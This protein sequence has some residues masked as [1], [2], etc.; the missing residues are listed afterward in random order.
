M[1]QR[2]GPLGGMSSGTNRVPQNSGVTG[3]RVQV[4]EGVR[5]GESYDSRMWSYRHREWRGESREN[6]RKSRAT[7]PPPQE[8]RS[9]TD[10]RNRGGAVRCD[11]FKGQG[12]TEEQFMIKGGVASANNSLQA[13]SSGR[14]TENGIQLGDEPTS[15]RSAAQNYRKFRKL[16]CVYMILDAYTPCGADK[17]QPEAQPGVQRVA[18]N[19]NATLPFG[20]DINTIQARTSRPTLTEG[21][22]S[23]ALREAEVVRRRPGQGVARTVRCA[24]FKQKLG[25][26]AHQP[27]SSYEKRIPAQESRLNRMT[28]K[29]SV[30][31]MPVA[32]RTHPDPRTTPTPSPESR[33]IPTP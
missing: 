6:H 30:V 15:F 32:A 1:P 18:I 16:R 28:R 13:R 9:E 24:T 26:Y 12:R 14:G 27:R 3:I 5:Q 20:A 21:P 2:A 23:E 19:L 7:A 11:A 17:L 33:Q 4:Q 25:S 31:S 8:K 29:D 22:D 10:G